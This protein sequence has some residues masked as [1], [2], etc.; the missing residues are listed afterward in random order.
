MARLCTI[1]IKY[2]TW[3]SKLEK[4]NYLEITTLVPL[5]MQLQKTNMKTTC[6]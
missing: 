3:H 2:N 1:L 6:E 5:Y 4:N